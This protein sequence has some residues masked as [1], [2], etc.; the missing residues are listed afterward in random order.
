MIDL[1]ELEQALERMT[2]RSVLFDLV[3]KEMLKRGHWKYKPRGKPV[4]ENLKKK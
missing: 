2:S 3:K 1:K 4:P